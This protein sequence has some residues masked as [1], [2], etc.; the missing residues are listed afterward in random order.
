M[1]N[2]ELERAIDFLLKSHAKLDVSVER[3]SERVSQLADTVSHLG[4][5]VSQLGDTVF[6]LNDTVT[7]LTKHQSSFA[8]TQANIMRVMMRTFEA[9][10]QIN[11]SLNDSIS[12]LTVRQEQTE[13]TVDRLSLKV[14]A[15]AEQTAGTDRRL[16][17]LIKIVEEGRGGR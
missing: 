10:A 5:T 1:T 12:K 7:Q 8:D 16:E 2:E 15:L 17:A 9:Q 11:Q 13:A 6:R 14:E 4:E 3:T